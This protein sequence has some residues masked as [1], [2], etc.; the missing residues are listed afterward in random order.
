MR[1]PLFHLPEHP[2]GTLQVEVQV[3]MANLIQQGLLTCGQQLP[4]CR[5]LATQLGISRNTVV[6]AYQKMVE[7]GL[8]IAKER[9]GYY[10]NPDLDQT[11]FDYHP[12]TEPPSVNAILE[13]VK[14]RRALPSSLAI[15]RRPEDW[16]QYPYPF[17]YG[18]I[19]TALFPLNQWR[20]CSR[21]ALNRTTLD[22]W[23]T[24]SSYCDAPEL[25]HQIK[26]HLLPRRGI[27]VADEQILITL[28]AQHALY[29]IG[30]L[31]GG[32][33]SLVGM[34]DPGYPDARNIFHLT[35]NQFRYLPVDQEGMQ[36]D[37][38]LN[39]CDMVYITPSHQFP[40]T[41]TMSLERRKQ[42]LEYAQHYNFM[43]IEDDYECEA[44]YCQQPTPALK[45]L[46][47]SS[48][49]IYVGSLSKSLFPGLRLG[50][51]VAHPDIIYEARS[52]RGAMLRHPPTTIQATTAKFIS[53]GHYDS[54]TRKTLNRYKKRWLLMQTLLEQ[55][56]PGLTL[57]TSFGGTAFWL[58]GKATFNASLFSEYVK[59]YGII[60]EPGEACFSHAEEGRHC[61]RLGFSSI[62]RPQIEQGIP[63]LGQLYRDF[64]RE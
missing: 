30:D 20:E 24:D 16:Y 33:G 38:R 27:Y 49:V 51:L 11:H 23:T 40:T 59:Q 53:F 62:T 32:A 36:V 18:Q 54:L 8:I 48:H 3:M 29:L 34:E 46:D 28:G 31:I 41:V 15:I 2:Q 45:S 21:L 26:T 25:I 1:H 44:N 50:Y 39:G 57:K 13:K 5:H 52:L 42:L 64:V 19:D 61:F 43:I 60:I 47:E 9:S 58:E 10:V 37:K 7:N 6:I 4:S 17:I 22:S 55:H 12:P 35:R 14:K 56:L 63:L